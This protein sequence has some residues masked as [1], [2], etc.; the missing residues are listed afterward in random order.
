MCMFKL[1]KQHME[2]YESLY[3]LF[4]FSFPSTLH[5]PPRCCL[6]L[7]LEL[8]ER[9]KVVNF[10]SITNVH[11]GFARENTVFLTDLNHSITCCL[12]NI[13]IEPGILYFNL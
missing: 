5:L 4:I 13:H 7:L 1:E 3:F 2:F 12:S 9:G 10:N 11:R 6:S 8:S